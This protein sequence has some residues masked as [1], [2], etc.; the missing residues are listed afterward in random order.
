MVNYPKDWE[1][2]DIG[3]CVQ[4]F[5]GGTPRTTNE[6]YWNG[7]IV[8]ITPG[9]ITQLDNL[10]VKDSERKITD[11]GLQNSSATLLPSGT[12]LLCTRATIGALAIAAKP[13]TTNQG[14]KNLVCNKNIYNIFFSYL[15]RACMDEMLSKAIGTTFLE[16]SK[17]TLSKIVVHIPDYKEQQAIADALT[18]FDTHINNLSKLIEKKK[19]IRD[20]A[21]EDLVS[22]KRRL[23]GFSGK[24]EEVNLRDICVENGLVRGP[25]GGSLKKECFVSKGYKVYEQKNAIY[26]DVNI[27][28][29]YIG[30]QKFEELKRFELKKDDFIV[31][32]SGTIG[33]IHRMPCNF[34]K[35]IINQALLKITLD[36]AKCNL[37]FFNI[38]FK[39]QKFQ[40]KI[41]DDTQG[42]A[43]KNL[44][45]MDKF[46]RTML[47]IPTSLSEQQ[48]IS[49]ILTAMDKEI[50]DLEEEKEKYIA[51]KAGAMDDLLTG[52]IRLV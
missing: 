49:D 10:F 33:K 28:N 52:K 7:N 6:A 43:I 46:K 12:I 11:L 45:G 22:G 42:G 14:F 2:T 48:A 21:V 18:A 40:M 44:V 26:G 19:M 1:I 20:G 36:S 3:S 15:L 5:Q 4:I 24:W 32:C 34:E 17:S 25:F 31:S 41:I 50:S 51:L 39:W 30:D 38:Y 35:G 16:I 8:W 9:E 29:Y 13:L 23:A 37:D 27:G 47:Y